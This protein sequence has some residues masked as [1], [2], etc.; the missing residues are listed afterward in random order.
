M[1]PRRKKPSKSLEKAARSVKDADDF[2]QHIANIADRYR[3][4]HALDLGP[5][6]RAVRQS[7]RAFHKHAAAL[8]GWLRQAQKQNGE[9]AEHD[10]LNKIGT[11]LYGSPV[12]AHAE[13]KNVL[14]WLAQAEQAAER[15]VA[16]AKPAAGKR[17]RNAPRLAAEGLRATFEHHK[18]KLSAP[19][20]KGKPGAAVFLLCA[21][22]S[23]AGDA[24]FTVE[25][26]KKS[27][28]ESGRQAA[29]ASAAAAADQRSQPRPMR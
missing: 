8:A 6:A 5:R 4:E 22:A 12:L 21:I 10:A 19:V 25:D 11:T 7:L 24:S 29:T 2:V 1:T 9:V 27:L 17:E 26:A 18:L 23:N 28:L 16:D 14:A 15:C 13:S 20:A 3:R